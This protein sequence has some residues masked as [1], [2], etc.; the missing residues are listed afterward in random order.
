M[1]RYPA[2]K[3]LSFNIAYILRHHPE[4]GSF[5]VAYTDSAS[6]A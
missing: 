1:S 4:L 2:G 6:T 5:P 3:F